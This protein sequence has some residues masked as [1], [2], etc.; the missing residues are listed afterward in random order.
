MAKSEIMKEYVLNVEVYVEK[1]R[2]SLEKSRQS[3]QEGSLVNSRQDSLRSLS[4]FGGDSRKSFENT[5]PLK[6]RQL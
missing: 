6:R 3:R 2:F 4:S 5:S 1:S